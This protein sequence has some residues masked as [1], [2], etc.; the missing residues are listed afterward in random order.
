MKGLKRGRKRKRREK[1]K[2]AGEE[3]RAGRTGGVGVVD[4]YFKSKINSL[5]ERNTRYR[6][7]EIRTG[8]EREIPTFY[9]ALD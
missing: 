1:K 3:S 4:L 5:E 8:R 9:K 2:R 7:K 6:R